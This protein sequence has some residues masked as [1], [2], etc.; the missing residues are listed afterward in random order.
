MGHLTNSDPRFGLIPCIISSTHIEKGEE[1]FIH[2]GYTLQNCPEWFSE[3]WIKDNYPVPNSFKEWG[4]PESVY[5]DPE[6]LEV[7]NSKWQDNAVN[8]NHS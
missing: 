3:A 1:I 4:I 8:S 7:D 6:I 5:S 2:Y